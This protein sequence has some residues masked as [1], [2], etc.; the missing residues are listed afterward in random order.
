MACRRGE[1]AAAAADADASG[2]DWV[3]GDEADVAAVG[4]EREVSSVAMTGL[5][6]VSICSCGAEVEG[7]GESYR[8][9]FDSGRG[10]V[11]GAWMLREG[12]PIGPVVINRGFE[13]Q[14]STCK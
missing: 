4:E 10:S 2:C 7:A 8:V 11:R 13:Q 9:V 3:E 1:A 12:L 5:M 14:G 6:M